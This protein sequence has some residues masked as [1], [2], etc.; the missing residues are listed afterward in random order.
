MT[1]WHF[2]SADSSKALRFEISRWILCSEAPD[3]CPPDAMAEGVFAGDDVTVRDVPLDD[4]LTVVFWP[5]ANP[6]AGFEENVALVGSGTGLGELLT[7][8][9]DPALRTW[10]LDPYEAGVPIEE[11]ISTVTA[12]GREF[13]DFPFG[14][15]PVTTTICYR[16][17]EDTWL[18]ANPVWLTH[19][20]DPWPPGYNGLYDWWTTLEIRDGSPI[21]YLHANLVAG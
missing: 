14:E 13:E 17:P 5:L 11:I 9:I 18:L 10:V 7:S 1:L 4:A 2:F 3:R 12:L 8:G 21:L 15:D 19:P 6:F 20:D 16:A